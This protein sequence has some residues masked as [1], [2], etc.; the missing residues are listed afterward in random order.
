[1]KDKQRL[2]VIGGPSRAGKT[3]V[4]NK[5]AQ[6]KSLINISTDTIRSIIRNQLSGIT[7]GNIG[8]VTFQVPTIRAIEN[9]S[10]EFT[11]NDGAEDENAWLGAIGIINFY[12]Q[13]NEA[14]ILIEGVAVDYPKQVREIKLNNLDAK[15]AFVGYSNESVA[16]EIFNYSM[17]NKD[18][19]YAD[20]Q[21]F[22]KGIEH[23]INFVR[24]EIPKNLERKKQA[25]EFGYGYF[26]RNEMS[27][28]KHTQAVID[29]LLND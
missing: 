6:Q 7:P 23:I 27:F 17:E 13:K 22:G 1:M 5:L 26:D 29:Y 18:H 4:A 2:Y 19:V 12:D 3:I 14:D 9:F 28:D 25:Q 8:K 24:N 11:R 20:M 10:M 15:V 21:R 16:Q